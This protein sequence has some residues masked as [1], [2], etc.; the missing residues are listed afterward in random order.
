MLMPI[1]LLLVAVRLVL[2][3]VPPGAPRLA[4][5]VCLCVCGVWLSEYKQTLQTGQVFPQNQTDSM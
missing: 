2:L 5:F 4:L 3:G 1:D